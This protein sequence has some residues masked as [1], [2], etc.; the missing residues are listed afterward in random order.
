L[1][2]PK[3]LRTWLGDHKHKTAGI[4]EGVDLCFLLTKVG[5]AECLTSTV[6]G[7]GDMRGTIS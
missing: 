4:V 2:L 1:P 7:G 6:P 3:R 5:P